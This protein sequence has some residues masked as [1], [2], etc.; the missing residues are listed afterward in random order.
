MFFC[1]N[2]IKTMFYTYIIQSQLNQKFYRG[3][4]ELDPNDRLKFHNK[5][6]VPATKENR[7]WKL[8]WFAGF[9]TKQKALNFEK[10]L[11]S[12]SGHAFSIKRF[13]A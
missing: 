7:P 1:Y 12:G 8:V 3:Y 2:K 10:Y 6:T 13:L 5:G 9:E 4:T 11:K